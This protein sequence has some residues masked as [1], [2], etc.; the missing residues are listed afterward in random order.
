MQITAAYL[1]PAPHCTVGRQKPEG[2]DFEVPVISVPPCGT[3]PICTKKNGPDDERGRAQ[4]I[5]K[6]AH[7][8]RKAGPVSEA[9]ASP[10][11]WQDVIRRCVL[12][13][14]ASLLGAL[15]TMVEQPRPVPELE[16][17]SVFESDFDQPP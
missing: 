15:T 1:Q 3:A 16:E 6:G 7:Y 5:I 2:I 9:I 11:E 17:Q 14:K 12:S 8:I 10:D 4:G 13:D